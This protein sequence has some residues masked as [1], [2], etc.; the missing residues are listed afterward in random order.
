MRR[1][2]ATDAAGVTPRQ[3]MTA[4]TLPMLAGLGLLLWLGQ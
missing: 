2:R 1:R 4:V 3:F